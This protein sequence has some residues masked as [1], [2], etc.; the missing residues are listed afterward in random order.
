METNNQ[1]NSPQEP[2][3]EPKKN[4]FLRHEILYS[5]IGILL[6]VLIVACVYLWETEKQV[7]EIS[8]LVTQNPSATNSEGTYYSFNIFHY[9]S[10]EALA[11]ADVA[12]ASTSAR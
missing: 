6:I 11:E 5:V 1:P 8:Q 4:W 9:L 2:Q 3:S 10:D 7:A 12:P